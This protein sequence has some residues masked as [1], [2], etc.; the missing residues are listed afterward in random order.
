MF[1]AAFAKLGLDFAYLAFRVK[2]EELEA[3]LAGLRALGFAGCNVT[4]PHKI[5]AIKHLDLLDETARASGT[6]NVIA[7][8]DGKLVGYNT[9]GAGALASLEANGVKLDNRTILIIGYGGAARALGF[10]LA[11]RRH[12]KQI[13]ILGRDAGK[14]SALSR[15][16]GR[17]VSSATSSPEA[18]GEADIIINATPLGMHP[19]IDQTPLSA[20]FLKEGSTVF[21][22]VYNPT[23]TRLLREARKR[24]CFVIGGLE[25]LVQQAGRA[26]T[27]WTGRDAPIEAMRRA[28]EEAAD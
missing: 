6:V 2:K 25:M 13:L 11:L 22:L 16:L 19:N 10:E 26:F 8:A 24:G 28:A 27:I 20:S 23:E 18:A 15:E 4:I 17:T 9:D 7:N 3:A 14:A 1:S 12:P 5:D 21:D